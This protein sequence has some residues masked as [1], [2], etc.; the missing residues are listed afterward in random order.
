LKPRRRAGHPSLFLLHGQK[1]R[2]SRQMDTLLNQANLTRESLRE[3]VRK[4][5]AK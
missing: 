3:Q 2:L 1:E 5:L 4:A